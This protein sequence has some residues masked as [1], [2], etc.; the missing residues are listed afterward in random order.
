QLLS[1][2]LLLTA[3]L[4]TM[5]Q[6]FKNQTAKVSFLAAPRVIQN[7]SVNTYSVE[8]KGYENNL[9][10]IGYSS[11]ALIDRVILNTFTKVNGEG[12]NKII[13]RFGGYGSLNGSLSSS[14]NSEG[15]VSYYYIYNYTLP[16][17]YEIYADNKRIAGGEIKAKQQNSAAPSVDQFSYK[18]KSFNSSTDANN[19]WNGSGKAEVRNHIKGN[20]ENKFK[21]FLAE[22]KYDID[23]YPST[24]TTSFGMFKTTKKADFTVYEKAAESAERALETLVAGQPRTGLRNA[25]DSAMTF[26]S[27][28]LSTLDPTNKE[29][30]KLFFVCANNLA[31]S[32]LWMDNIDS[33]LYFVSVAEKA[34]FREGYLSM[35]KYEIETRQKQLNTLKA[36]GIDPYTGPARAT[37][38]EIDAINAKAE[39]D[40]LNKEAEIAARIAAAEKKFAPVIEN[41]DGYIIDRADKKVSGKIICYK[42]NNGERTGKNFFVADGADKEMELTASFVKACEFGSNKYELVKYADATGL[43]KET[44]LLL[45]A[46]ESNK[47]KVYKSYYKLKNSDTYTTDIYYKRPDEEVATNTTT[48]AFTVAYKKQLAKYFE[49]CAEINKKALAGDYTDSPEMRIAAAVDYSNS[50]K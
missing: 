18:S 27:T 24:A 33:A 11:G 23:Y 35:L 20:F 12:E 15:K 2:T 14:T 49:N 31:N 21:E 17:S 36:F 42:A 38:E 22:V 7:A 6:N 44:Q 8:V 37:Q 50:C 48:V 19:F 9:N 10:D 1:L 32:Y 30:D 26:W 3:S 34:K 47:I 5:G 13:F 29:Q 45:V 4:S 28:T 46:Y 43:G 40:R 16:M 39:E 41:Y 25:L